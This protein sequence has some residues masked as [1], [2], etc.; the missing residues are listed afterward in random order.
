MKRSY[1]FRASL[2]L[3]L[4]L[5]M[6]SCGGKKANNET[7][8]DSTAAA[9]TEAIT[10]E[11]GIDSTQLAA[12]KQADFAQKLPSPVHIARIFK[13]SG[14]KYVNGLANPVEN[15]AKYVSNESRSL[16]LGVYSADLAY[17]ALNKQSD[18][19][20]KYFKAVNS[21]AEGLNLSSIFEKNGFAKRFESNLS[22]QDSL[23][24]LMTEL[25][26]ESDELLKETNR[27]DIVNLSF[28]GAWVESMYLA[29]KIYSTQSNPELGNRIAQQGPVLSALIKLLK[30]QEKDAA[31]NS[32]ATSL[33][34]I[35]AI[36][37]ALSATSGSA[38]PEW[39]EKFS[40]ELQPKIEALRK[41]IIEKA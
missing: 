37:D 17:S 7:K 41:S 25:Q 32:L 15:T 19:A 14:L 13:K 30:L 31:A 26:A 6:A 35:Q 11:A 5:V 34:E 36:M 27:Y 39:K 33:G 18:V 4:P 22:N 9:S 28:G 20:G 38:S 8:T 12:N 2:M 29:S 3:A 23:L 21:V 16:N 1:L 10:N 24:I 40:K